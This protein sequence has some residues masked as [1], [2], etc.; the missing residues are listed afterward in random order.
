MAE[1]DSRYR[2][3]MQASESE[4]LA[5]L[6]QSQ[7]SLQSL[8]HDLQRR[9][10]EIIHLRQNFDASRRE[11]DSRQA[12]LHDKEML[13]NVLRRDLEARNQEILQLKESLDASCL[14][15]VHLKLNGRELMTFKGTC[16]QD[17][18]FDW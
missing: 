1:L 7:Q 17:L 11:C 6:Q 5:A 10:D 13:L 8:Q 2:G 18:Y 3:C 12:A 4:P 9:E 15:K 16:Y 14:E